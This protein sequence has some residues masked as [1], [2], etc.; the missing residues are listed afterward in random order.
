[1][2]TATRPTEPRTRT[3][4]QCEN[5]FVNCPRCGDTASVMPA[6][7]SRRGHRLIRCVRCAGGDFPAELAVGPYVEPESPGR[8][9]AGYADIHGRPC[10]SP[11]PPHLQAQICQPRPAVRSFTTTSKKAE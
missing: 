5:E 1:M 10:R 7:Q 2:S 11:W 3:L 4:G 8:G 9:G 6:A